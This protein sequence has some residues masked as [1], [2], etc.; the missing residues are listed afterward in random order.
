ME[1]RQYGRGKSGGQVRDEFRDDY[2]AG[3]GGFGKLI[4]HRVDKFGPVGFDGQ[5]NRRFERGKRKHPEDEGSN[6]GDG[7]AENVNPEE[8][9]GGETTDRTTD[10]RLKLQVQIIENFSD[11]CS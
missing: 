8:E 9:E 3:R 10:L 2:D 7:G 6:G 4:Q 1:G 5:P 11:S